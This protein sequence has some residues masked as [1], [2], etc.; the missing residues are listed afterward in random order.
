MVILLFSHR[1]F[2]VP[3]FA[4]LRDTVLKIDIQTD[5]N[6]IKEMKKHM[7]HKLS[8]RYS[9]AQKEYL[10]SVA[11]LDPRFKSTVNVNI[12]DFKSTVKTICEQTGNH[13]VPPTQSQVPENIET[14]TFATP[15]ASNN[16]SSSEG[17]PS[18]YYSWRSN[19][20]GAV[21]RRHCW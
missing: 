3:M 10:T 12:T 5:S 7:L 20:Q 8:T 16:R 4:I 14:I 6:T 18:Q 15:V 1:R 2:F 21:S 9:D 17:I 19:Y 11:Y 13:I